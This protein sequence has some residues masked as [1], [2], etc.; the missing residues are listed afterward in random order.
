LPVALRGSAVVPAGNPTTGFTVAVPS[1][2][3]TGDLLFLAVT[4]RDST[5]AG[6]LAVTDNDTGG[7]AWAKIA[8]STDH[9]ATLWYKRATS[10][11]A[12]KTVTVANAVGSSSGVLKCFGG[13]DTGATPYSNVVVESNASG[14]ESAAGWTP[15]SAD[16]M[17]CA[18]VHNYSND[19][20][21][22]GLTSATYG[23]LTST[24]KLSTG[25]SDCA[26]HFGHALMSGGSATGT[27]SWTQ[28]TNGA[29]YTISWA[30]KPLLAFAATAALTAG[31]ATLSGSATSADPVYAGAAAL[32][33]GKASLAGTATF[34]GP[35]VSAAAALSAPAAVLA[36]TAQAVYHP[37]ARLTQAVH[38]LWASRYAGF[39][40]KTLTPPVYSGSAALTAPRAALSGAAYPEY[41]HPV[42]RLTQSTYG[43]WASR[44]GSFAEKG[45]GE[46]AAAAVL[47]AGPAALSAAATSADPV[48]AATGALAAGRATLAASATAAD[49]VYA[50]TAA[51]AAGRATLAGSATSADPVYAGSAALNSP[52][53]ALSG[54][55]LFAAQVYQGNAALAAGKATLAG[56]ATATAPFL[57][58]ANLTGPRA[59]LAGAAVSADPAY[60]GT[61]A[62]NA[63]AAQFVGLESVQTGVIDGDWPRVSRPRAARS[64][65]RPRAA[66]T[67]TRA[68]R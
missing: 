41:E 34:T 3:V 12:S 19:N 45:T 67:V 42:G 26:C 68:R 66:R 24:E 35:A 25:G 1:Q 27:L 40:G 29:S 65:A 5:G 48:Y 11:T 63:P 6:T 18:S 56:S 17:L 10:G 33:T 36:G 2:V 31:P 39:G 46:F 8:N 43:L 59:T 13:G 49:P 50:A 55:A 47:S 7:N 16:S 32:T 51:L 14:D 15:A 37:V 52:R 62:L 20:A 30:V 61:A 9:K 38:G 64:V 4:S 54:S 21:I 60:S 44:Y 22:T 57:A 53:A 28:A 58:T 23:A